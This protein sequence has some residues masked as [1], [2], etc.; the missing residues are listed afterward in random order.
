MN[1]IQT[2]CPGNRQQRPAPSDGSR[3]SEPN[4]HGAV[5]TVGHP[6][7]GKPKVCMTRAQQILDE[8][9]RL[10]TEERMAVLQGV[11][12]L[13]ARASSRR[14]VSYKLTEKAEADSPP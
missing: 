11:V 7:P 13:V 3:L 6:G 1:L 14:R 12:D 2:T 4:P 10:P 9:R 8:V 5:W